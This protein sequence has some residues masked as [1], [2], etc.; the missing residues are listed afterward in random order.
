MSTASDPFLRARARFAKYFS[1]EDLHAFEEQFKVDDQDGSGYLN[2]ED[3]K[4]V[5]EK[6]E[7]PITHVQLKQM[8]STIA[9][10]PE[11]GLTFDDFLKVQ[12]VVQG[13]DLDTVELGPDPDAGEKT[14]VS[15]M[16]W[17]R[18]AEDRTITKLNLEKVRAQE[19]EKMQRRASR[20]DFKKTFQCFGQLV[21]PR[22][23]VAPKK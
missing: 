23:T 4:R 8:I 14:Q 21:T 13:V 9:G 18:K 12:L 22:R 16:F 3:L 19:Q 7:N 6:L 20:D 11:K 2:F 17:A 5:Q 1:A 15:F 10:D